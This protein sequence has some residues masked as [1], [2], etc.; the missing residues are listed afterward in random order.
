MRTIRLDDLPDE[1][2]RRRWTDEN[3]EDAGHLFIAIYNRYRQPVRDELEAAGLT[4]RDAEERVGSVFL[5][6]QESASAGGSL[7]EV[8]LTVARAV[9]RD[10]NWSPP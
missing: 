3:F 8:L 9:A 5:R 2:L 10:S 6:A 7:R 4:P 1:E